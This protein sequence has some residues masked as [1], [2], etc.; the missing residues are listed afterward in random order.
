MTKDTRKSHVEN[1]MEALSL[2]GDYVTA[3]HIKTCN[4]NVCKA[5]KKGTVSA[6]AL[7]KEVSPEGGKIDD[8]KPPRVHISH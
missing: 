7:Y 3:N 4:C 5:L 1:V 6:R 8:V 2:V